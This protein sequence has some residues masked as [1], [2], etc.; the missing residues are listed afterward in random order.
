MAR[1]LQGYEARLETI[2]QLTRGYGLRV[3]FVTQ[4]TLWNENLSERGR[5]LLWLGDITEGQYLSIEA[6]RAGI[7]KHN[8]VLISVCK[9]MDVECINTESMHGQER[10]FY[11][12][13]HFTEAGTRELARLVAEHFLGHAS[14]N[15]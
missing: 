7:D 3:V 6:G 4:P 5:G 1:A 2:V 13:F 11:D 8:D 14:S 12:D 15:H 10:Y 9:R